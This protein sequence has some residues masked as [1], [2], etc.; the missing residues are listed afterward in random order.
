[1]QDEGGKP[2]HE[3][4]AQALDS[5]GD[6]TGTALIEHIERSHGEDLELLAEVRSLLGAGSQAS[7]PLL[8]DGGPAQELA[9]KLQDRL[10]TSELFTRG[11]TPRTTHDASAPVSM[12][13]RVSAYDIRRMV[14]QG[15]MGVVYEAMQASPHRRVAIK[16]LSSSVPTRTALARFRRE[17]EVLG[18]LKHP[19]IAQV[20]EAATDPASGAAFFAMEYVDGPPLTAFAQHNQLSVA[21]RVELLAR[22]CDA[23]QHAHQA[24]VIHR[25]LKPSNILVEDSSDGTGQP[26]VLDFGVASLSREAEQHATLSLDTGKIIGTL[27]YMP[28]EAIDGSESA[29]TRGDIYSLGVILYELLA[30]RLPVDV[31]GA[32]LTEA[33]RRIREKQPEPLPPLPSGG[34]RGMRDDLD[35]IVRKALAKEAALRYASAAEFA[36]DLRRCLR[37]EP[38]LA[39]PAST[40]Y[41]L[42]KFMRRRQGVSALVAA[43]ALLVISAAVVATAQY[44]RANQALASEAE[45]RSLAERKREEAERGQYRAALAAAVAAIRTQTPVEA[46]KSLE[47]AP[48]DLRGW[49][50]RYLHSAVHPGRGVQLPEAVRTLTSFANGERVLS[51]SRVT[52]YKTFEWSTG[53]GRLIATHALRSMHVSEDGA[54]LTGIDSNGYV[55]CLDASGKVLWREPPLAGTR[56]ESPTLC[57]VHDDEPWRVVIFGDFAMTSVDAA[58]GERQ[59]LTTSEFGC[60]RGIVQR[61][62]DAAYPLIL[63]MWQASPT[64]QQAWIDVRNGA[65]IPNGSQLRLSPPSINMGVGFGWTLFL[66]FG[67]E[68]PG[69][70]A[71]QDAV[72]SVTKVSHDASMIAMGDTRGVVTM[73]TRDPANE[74]AYLDAGTLPMG[75]GVIQAITFLRDEHEIAT[76]DQT[77][78]V[79]IAS[80]LSLQLPYRTTADLR[81]SPGPISADGSRAM[82]IGWGFVSVTD[83]LTGFPLWRRNLG[84][85]FPGA[86]AFSPDGRRI[87]WFGDREGTWNEFFVLDAE[88]GEQ[89]VGYSTS[90]TTIDPAHGFSLAPWDASVRAVS[91]DPH[92]PRLVSAHIDGTLRVI[93][94]NTWSMLP[95][96]VARV[97]AVSPVM[98]ALVHSPDG[99]KVAVVYSDQVERMT[100]A[101]PVMVVDAVT[102]ET[103]ATLPAEEAAFAAAWSSDSNTLV[104]GY[105]GGVVCGWDSTKATR[106]WRTDLGSSDNIRTVTVSPDGQRIAAAAIGPQMHILN[107]GGQAVA[108]LPS[109]VAEVRS[110]HFTPDDALLATAIRAQV[111]RYGVDDRERE[112]WSPQAIAAWPQDVPR[113]DSLAEARNVIQ[114]ADMLVTDAM[115]EIR[116]FGVRSRMIQQAASSNDTARALAHHWLT[117]LGPIL[118]W[119]NS[120]ALVLMRDRPNDRQSLEYARDI[121]L[122]LVDLKP[123]VFNLRGNLAEVYHRLGDREKAIEMMRN[124]EPRLANMSPEFDAAPYAS[125]AEFYVRVRDPENARRV[126]ATI[127]GHLAAGN[128]RGAGPTVRKQLEDVRRAIDELTSEASPSR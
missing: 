97:Q 77:G 60:D 117:R 46:R 53:D 82:S 92:R 100:R 65:W 109:P 30:G 110:L 36:A 25:D 86:T 81:T 114:Q 23:T 75:S 35:L 90:P 19:G 10:L 99:S 24:G 102:L 85:T 125:V 108:T 12:P 18:R 51:E 73:Y 9:R 52:P 78:A 29:D 120:D 94:T 40:W 113:P 37:H 1:M 74:Y 58:T 121:L 57:R 66:R 14:G 88:T 69:R 124:A 47:E 119:G 3:R 98:H 83:T 8:D 80:V 41:T 31:R 22:V 34:E 2:L 126:L 39:R 70:A 59:W 17:A 104:V 103:L 7:V 6:L 67:E 62:G 61:T 55:V 91:F 118:T 16:M 64:Q 54:F 27:G 11:G 43:S 48:A 45:Q 33:A 38:V 111:V 56:W 20:F 76:V 42:R 107:R 105:S 106:L 116:P 72:W 89:L 84:R 68:Y 28:P 50:W 101:Q 122:E 128:T 63:A 79:R 32:S 96:P 123:H 13:Q 112:T 26:K 93:E 4:V 115:S 127:D 5:A 87:V 15:G 95:E 44:V 71:P 49:E 21:Q